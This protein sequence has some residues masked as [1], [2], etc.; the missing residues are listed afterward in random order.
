MKPRPEIPLDVRRHVFSI[1]ADC[2]RR[3][4][5][6]LAHIPNL[7]E[8]SL[9]H[10]FIEHFTHHCK[11]VMMPSNWTIR[12]DCHFI[13]GGRHYYRWEIADFGI[14]VVF[15]YQG[16]IWLSK[17]ALL[18]SKRLF[19]TEFD[20]VE[21]NPL[22]DDLGF[23][24]LFMNEDRWAAISGPRDFRFDARSLYRSLE[25][26]N[27]QYSN[28]AKY[29]KRHRIPVHYLLYNPLR[30]PHEVR[31]PIVGPENEGPCEVGCRVVPSKSLR[32][33][34]SAEHLERPPRF[35][36]LATKLPSPF[37]SQEAAGGWRLENY[38]VD[39]LLACK[40]GLV[41]ET[42]Q[43]EHLRH[44]FSQKTQ[45]IHAALVLTFDMPAAP[46]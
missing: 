39:E 31:F 36:E 21:S 20:G 35:G 27:E 7:H 3:V 11:P 25:I 13:G 12:F 24:Y 16:Q 5:T 37:N 18:Q 38:I 28:I 19:P 6:K 40:D 2:N 44:V 32:A 1:F 9:D 30:V 43:F 46:E 45:P 33:M 26:A 15:R 17:V 34:V 23:N 10:S 29:E 22:D 41:D 8:T 42:S 4:S 14:L